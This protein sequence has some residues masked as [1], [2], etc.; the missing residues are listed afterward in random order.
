M[1]NIFRWSVT[2]YKYSFK[3]IIEENIQDEP[4]HPEKSYNIG[5]NMSNVWDGASQTISI[6]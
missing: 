4:S 1:S 6:P 5:M 2:D 3:A